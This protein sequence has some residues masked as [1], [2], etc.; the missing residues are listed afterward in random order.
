MNMDSLLFYLLNK[1][2][3]V[4]FYILLL[5]KEKLNLGVTERIH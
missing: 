2:M 4:L 3:L 1:L 5:Y